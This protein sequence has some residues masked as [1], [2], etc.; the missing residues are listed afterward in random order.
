M[1]AWTS[2]MASLGLVGLI[3]AQQ[4]PQPT[5]KNTPIGVTS[6]ASGKQMFNSYCASCHGLDGKGDGPVRNAL[7][8]RPSDLTTLAQKN[9]GG[10]PDMRVTNVILGRTDFTSHGSREMPVWGPL[11]SQISGGSQAVVHQRVTNLT[12]YIKSLQVK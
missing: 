11:F 12:L 5:V 1:R 2:L 3:T 10:F 6:P 7:K 4:Q 8:V 9:G